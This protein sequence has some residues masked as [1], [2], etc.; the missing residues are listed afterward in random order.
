MVE[1]RTVASRRDALLERL[2]GPPGRYAVLCVVLAVLWFP[3]RLLLDKGDPIALIVVSSGLHGVMWA[4]LTL[5]VEWGQRM[6]RGAVGPG[7]NPSSV[8][9][10]EHRAWARR[11]AIVGLGVSVPF[12]GTLIA[13]CLITDRSWAYTASFG[14]IMLAMIAVAIS[15]LRHST[16]ASAA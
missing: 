8:T 7:D 11:G 12:Y 16:E 4:L 10:V 1:Q 3:F 6:R 15:S 13:L 14:V 9:A 2:G 5:A